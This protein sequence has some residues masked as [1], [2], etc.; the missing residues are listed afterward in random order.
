MLHG[1]ENSAE[2]IQKE[3]CV[4]P[5]LQDIILF[6]KGQQN[7]GRERCGG[8]AGVKEEE[9]AHNGIRFQRYLHPLLEKVNVSIG[10]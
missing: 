2:F 1:L 5:N 9:L 10:S 3:F 7:R 8:G 6:N 4:C